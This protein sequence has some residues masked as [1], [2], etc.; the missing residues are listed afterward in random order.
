MRKSESIPGAPGDVFLRIGYLVINRDR[1]SV[2]WTNKTKI[3][4]MLFKTYDY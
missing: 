3:K 2:K 4:V 1:K